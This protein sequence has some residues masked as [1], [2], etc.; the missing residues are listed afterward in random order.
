[1]IQHGCKR[2]ARRAGDMLVPMPRLTRNLLFS[3]LLLAPIALSQSLRLYV[4]DN[5]VTLR[6]LSEMAPVSHRSVPLACTIRYDATT[7]SEVAISPFFS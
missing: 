2:A 4:F 5:G 6:A 1:M 7:I 3:L